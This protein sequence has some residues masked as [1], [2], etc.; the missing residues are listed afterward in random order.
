M[1]NTTFSGWG[2][3]SGIQV[4]PA[5][6]L[7]RRRV[8][9]GAMKAGLAVQRVTCTC[10]ERVCS[11]GGCFVRQANLPERANNPLHGHAIETYNLLIYRFQKS[12]IAC[13]ALQMSKTFPKTMP[14]RPQKTRFLDGDRFQY[15]G[16]VV[17]LS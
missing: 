16:G 3:A 12:G 1:T 4:V 5:Q 14:F 17:T 11:C 13:P 10:M 2:S 15:A 8:F 7:Y 6:A 9:S